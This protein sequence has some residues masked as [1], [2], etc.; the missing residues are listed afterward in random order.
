MKNKQNKNILIAIILIVVLIIS[1]LLLNKIINPN[2]IQLI[3]LSPQ[4]QRQ[5]MGYIIKTKRGKTIIIDGGTTDDTENLMK[6]INKYNNKVDYWF[7][8]HIHDDHAG[9]F[10]EI[11]NNTE[12][13][14]SNIYIS[15]NEYEW[16]ERNEPNRFEFSKKVIDT[17]NS[18]K[19]KQ[20]VHIPQINEKM[21]IDD[22]EV[23]ILGIRNPE[24]TEN[25]GNEQSMVIKFDTGKG[26]LLI[27]GDTGEKSSKKL[28]E[29]QRENLKSDI[30][31]MAHHGQAG[32][33][34]E[35]YEAVSPT[36]C[37]WPTPEWLW[38]NDAGSG[39]NSGTWKTL[40]TRKWMED[41]NVK[42]NYIA[43][44]GDFII[45]LK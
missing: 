9:A 19:R 6:Y 29:T 20:S 5:M 23:K 45:K 16:Y 32:A 38:N 36:I 21:L 42:T 3:G 27:L 31:Q 39:K 12:V 4:G 14:I 44:D 17:V 25:S 33:T 11:A 35:L 2:T 18:E 10:T 15:L 7:I 1:A 13:E 43:K 40:E 34:K 41:L 22:I 30:V 24:I 26:T 28:L 8:T 37:L